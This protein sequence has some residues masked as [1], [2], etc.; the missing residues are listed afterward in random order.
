[1]TAMHQ[2]ASRGETTPLQ[3]CAW[4]RLW[5]LLLAPVESQGTSTVDGSEAKPETTKPLRRQAE[6][7]DADAPIRPQKQE[8][9]GAQA[10]P[11]HSCNFSTGSHPGRSLHSDDNYSTVPTP[12]K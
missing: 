2:G 1:M 6:P 12:T 9:P 7:L 10:T 8:G 3:L 5:R 11:G 4:R